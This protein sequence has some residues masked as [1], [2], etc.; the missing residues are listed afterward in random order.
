[1]KMD[2]LELAWSRRS[3]RSF[4]SI[5][6]PAAKIIKLLDAARSAPSGGNCQP[7]HFYVIYNSM[8]RQQIVDLACSQSFMEKAPVL[9]VVCIDLAR[10]TEVY[11]NRG[12][13]LYGIQDTAAAIQN[14]L[15]CAVDEGLAACWVGAFDEEAV[16][17]LLMTGDYMRPIAVIPVGYAARKPTPV[18]RRSIGEISTF[19]G[20][21]GS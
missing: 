15:L 6:V 1:M 13:D 5:D 14:L 7:W 19:I 8:V 12:K 10:T 9:I 16:A 18:S 3:V 20:F 11:G 2:F 21:E 4:K 17:D